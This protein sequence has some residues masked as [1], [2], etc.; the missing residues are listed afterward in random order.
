MHPFQYRPTY[1]HAKVGIFDDNWLTIGSANLNDRG[2]VTDSEMNVVVRDASLALA[3]RADLWAEHLA[4]SPDEVAAADPVS[5]VETTWRQ[6]A[7]DNAAIMKTA[8]KP[9]TSQV[10]LYECGRQPEDW[11]L[12]ESQTLTFEH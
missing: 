1:V 2:L 6:R 9:L 11:L 7:S 12:A 5:L 4:L 3:T 8:Q 10:H